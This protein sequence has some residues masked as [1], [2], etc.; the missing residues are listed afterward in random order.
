MTAADK[1]IVLMQSFKCAMAAV[2]PG[3]SRYIRTGVCS[4]WV[5]MFVSAHQPTQQDTETE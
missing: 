3:V 4:K 1:S 5:W 2:L